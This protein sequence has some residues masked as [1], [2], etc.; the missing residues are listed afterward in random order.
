MIPELTKKQQEVLHWIT[1]GLTNKQIAQRLKISES[2]VKLHVGNIF[3]RYGVKTR[4]ALTASA[5]T[6]K[7]TTF[8][9]VDI[10][11]KPF[12][13]VRIK[14]GMVKGIVFSEESPANDWVSLYKRK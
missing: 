9:P 5:I 11:E 14:R 8:T 3:K 4:S 10:E 12:A 13:W 2:T 6:H 1:Q 7:V